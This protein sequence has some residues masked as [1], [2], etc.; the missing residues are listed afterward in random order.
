LS[1]RE[2]KFLCEDN[3]WEVD[4]GYVV[5]LE[6]KQT[7]SKEGTMGRSSSNKLDPSGYRVEVKQG[8]LPIRLNIDEWIR[9]LEARPRVPLGLFNP[10]T[11]VGSGVGGCGIKLVRNQ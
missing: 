10:L 11:N 3:G 6:L 2:A 5:E 8:R 1:W 4:L 7:G 9:D